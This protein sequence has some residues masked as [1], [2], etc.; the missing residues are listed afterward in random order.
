[1][2][3]SEIPVGPPVSSATATSSS[4][5]AEAI[6]SASRWRTRSESA[7]TRPPPPRRTVRS[8]FSSRSNWAGPRFETMIRGELATPRGYGRGSG[9]EIADQAEPVPQQA[10]REELAAGVLLAVAA[11]ALAQAGVAKDL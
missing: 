5:I 8:P 9:V 2:S 6:Q 7:V 10:R 4:V 11:E 3:P 1:M